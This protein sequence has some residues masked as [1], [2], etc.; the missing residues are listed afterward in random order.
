MN[1]GKYDILLGIDWL[2]VHNPNINW[3]ISNVHL[4]H[5]PDMC[6][7]KISQDIHIGHMELLPTMEW[8][9]QYN[10]HF[11]TIYNGIDVS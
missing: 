7:M 10:D 3:K 9:P 5:C 1:I 4:N 6:T 11:K 8:K 2:K